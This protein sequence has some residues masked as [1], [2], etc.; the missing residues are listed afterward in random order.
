MDLRGSLGYPLSYDFAVHNSAF[1]L[2]AF[3]ECQGVQHYMPVDYFGGEKQFLVQKQND[4]AKR[5]Y[6]DRMAIPLL[7]IPYFVQG[8]EIVQLLDRDLQGVL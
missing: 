6:A 2:A 1:S 4:R 7:E 8:D 3:I 5:E